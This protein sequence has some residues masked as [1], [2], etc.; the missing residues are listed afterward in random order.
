VKDFLTQ[1]G[2]RWTEK[3][4]DEDR[5]AAIEMIRRSGQRGVP[6]TVI[7]DEVIVGF[8]RPRLERAVA[9]LRARAASGPTSASR[10]RR[11]LGAKVADAGRFAL[12]GGTKAQGAYV[13]G[14]NPG[15]PAEAAGLKTGD[16]ITAV[17]GKPIY[18]ADELAKELAEAADDT[19]RLTVARGP[20]LREVQVRLGYPG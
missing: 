14:V 17:N 16:V 7:G 2:V 19:V 11:K 15:S 13:G 3:Y 9:A 5:D 20:T 4:V 18:T 1:R 8:D 10:P 12:P 6:V